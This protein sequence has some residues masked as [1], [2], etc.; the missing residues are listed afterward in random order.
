MFFFFGG[1]GGGGEEI[2]SSFQ[3]KMS[4]NHHK[5]RRFII[6]HTKFNGALTQSTLLS[7]SNPHP[8]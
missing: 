5:M 3:L 8:L 4:L 1:G 7:T 6:R 2:K